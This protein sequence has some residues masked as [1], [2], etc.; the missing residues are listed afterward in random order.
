V[1]NRPA[2]VRTNLINA[3]V[4]KLAL[5]SLV[6]VKVTC[7]NLLA[8]ICQHLPG[9]DVDAV[10]Y[11]VGA[12]SRIGPKYLRGGLGYGGPCLP[13]DVR[14]LSALCRELGIKAEVPDS[15]TATNE[16]LAVLVADFVRQCHQ[17]SG[18]VGVLGLAYRKGTRIVE[19]SQAVDLV[20]QLARDLT[21][22]HVYDPL[23]RASG[24]PQLAGLPVTWQPDIKSVCGAAQ[25]L[26]IASQAREFTTG[27]E[28]AWLANR[29]IVDCWRLLPAETVADWLSP[30]GPLGF[31][32]FAW[33]HGPQ[34][35][36]DNV[37]TADQ[38][39]ETEAVSLTS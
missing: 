28:P 17:G 22:V 1:T 6:S 11:A 32:Y 20:R 37:S 16:R 23:V 10:T 19:A 3:E 18:A 36:S 29:T 30:D 12:D 25:T 2:V 8:E 4:A 38:L 14:A 34:G 33:G 15:V 26:V 9:A 7:A 35:A 13:R 24:C 5:N 39:E 27:L 21:P 31:R